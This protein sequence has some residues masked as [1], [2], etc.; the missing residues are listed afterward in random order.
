MIWRYFL[1]ILRYTF[2]AEKIGCNWTKTALRWCWL[3]FDLQFI[4]FVSLVQ[5]NSKSSSLFN[6]PS[7]YF[8]Y[9]KFFQFPEQVKFWQIDAKKIAKFISWSRCFSSFCMKFILNVCKTIYG[10]VFRENFSFAVLF[11]VSLSLIN[12]YW[13][14]RNHYYLN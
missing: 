10:I 2:F 13:E 7:F 5:A 12:L 8:K 14:K 3:I 9:F 4:G 1:N 11:E 6:C